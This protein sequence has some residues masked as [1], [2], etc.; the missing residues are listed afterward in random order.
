MWFRFNFIP[1]SMLLSPSIAGLASIVLGA[2]GV[3][4][5]GGFAPVVSPPG[6]CGLHPADASCDAVFEGCVDTLEDR[7][8]PF[9]NP[10]CVAAASCWPE[11][12]DAFLSLL[13]CRLQGPSGSV[14]HS[15]TLPRVS[16][17]VFNDT[18]IDGQDV[19]LE[20]YTSWYTKTAIASNSNVT[21]LIDPAFVRMSFDIILAWTGFCSSGLIPMQNFLDWFQFFSIVKGP[22]TSCGLVEN[23]PISFNPYSQDL[24]VACS[25]DLDAVADPFGIN[26]CVA[27][28]LNWQDG[29][30]SFLRAVVCRHN[31]RFNTSL[32]VPFGS[33][34]PSLS[35]RLTPANVPR[36]TR[37]NFIDFTFRTLTSIGPGVR[38]PAT[39]NFV[40]QRWTIIVAWTNSCRTGIVRR[41]NLSDFLQ[42]SS[43]PLTST[44]CAGAACFP[45]IDASC[46]Q[47]FQS[48][49]SEISPA[50]V[51]PFASVNC[52]LSAT[53]HPNTVKTFGTDVSCA[54]GAFRKN[55]NPV[56]WPRLTR[57]T[58]HELSGGHN[59]I[60]QQNY[61]DAFY[62]ALAALPSPIWPNVED[63]IA[64]WTHVKEWTG[65]PDGNVPFKNF[66]DFLQFS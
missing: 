37:Q 63:V 35:I 28:A 51:N 30:D 21:E 29:V 42:H 14:P 25:S 33:Q 2:V 47:L 16:D 48:C 60:S 54:M 59:T 23:C 10:M 53:C 13:F 52:V 65:F 46:Q 19:S 32:P 41:K 61:I 50:S 66:V 39:V 36:F 22:G 8:A 9:S 57:T 12:P 44:A 55:A 4:A 18:A 3:A 64:R 31:I 26:T 49:A 20:S 5:T 56:N 27:G 1:Q 38:F 17:D 34:V 58:F 11:N 15:V 62:G 24:L 6:A 40:T 7:S 43:L 45:K